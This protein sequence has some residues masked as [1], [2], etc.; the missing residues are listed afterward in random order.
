MKISFYNINLSNV[1]YHY[2]LNINNDKLKNYKLRN[3]RIASFKY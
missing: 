1:A 3:Y 2:T